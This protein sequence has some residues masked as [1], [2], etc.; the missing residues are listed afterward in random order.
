M[1]IKKFK[2]FLLEKISV[3]NTDTP[4]TISLINKTND[5]QKNIGEFSSKKNE[6]ENVYLISPDEITL[7][8]NLKKGG[9]IESG[10]TKSEMVFKNPILGKYA[11]VCDFKKQIK[12][13]QDKES[14]INTEV[15]EKESQMSSN[16]SMQ[17]SFSEDIKSKKNEIENIKKRLSEIKS[18][19]D[20]LERMTMKEFGEL[21]KD[22]TNDTKDIRQ[23]RSELGKK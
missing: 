4:S 15:K 11:T 20:R 1:I 5:L 23:S 3:S 14:R 13:L 19:S 21:Q 12:D 10:T 9:F 22:L 2:I 18:E 7:I 17:T 6:L 16:P 8:E